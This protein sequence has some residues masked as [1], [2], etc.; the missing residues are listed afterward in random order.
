MTIPRSSEILA[1]IPARA[2]SKGIPG[3]NLVCV[4]GKPLIAW[5]IDAA[6]RASSIA[7]VVVT[8]DGEDI[9][10]IARDHGAEVPFLRPAYLAEDRTP[11]IDPILHAIRWFE[12][13]ENYVPSYVVMLQPTSPLRSSEDIEAAIQIA[14]AREADAVVSVCESHHHPSW[15]K[16]IDDDGRLHDF[17]APN[18]VHRRQDLQ[19]VYVLN[20]AIYLGR[21]SVLNAQQTFYT[22]HTFAYI[23]PPERSL[24]IDTAWHME[25][26]EI[27]LV[28]RSGD[29]LHSD[30][31]PKRR[32][33]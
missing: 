31:T 28:Q 29:G 30:R 19:P 5:T 16:T 23:M 15:M 3:K 9:A 2:G 18:S 13:R 17:F 21:R 14:L 1:I 33:R 6:I 24:D 10:T 27:L 4:G 20:G 12:E 32:R 7:R 22:D 26:A 11:G 8:T 25:L